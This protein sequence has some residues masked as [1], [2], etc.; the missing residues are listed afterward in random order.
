MKTDMQTFCQE[1]SQKLEP[2]ADELRQAL[3]ELPP[4]E[5][6]NQIDTTVLQLQEVQQRLSTLREK[7]SDQSTFLLIFG[8]LKS[9]KSTLMNALS[10]AYVSE[11]SSLPAYPALV[12][13]KNGD[14]H[15][16]QATD[17]LGERREF[18]DN[19]AL[20]EAIQTDHSLLADAIV[21]AENTSAS[22]DP[23]QHYPQAIRRM[24]IEI[25]AAHLADSGSV[26]VDTP[27]LYSR[28]KFGYDQMTRDFRDTAACAIFVVKTDNLFFEKVFEEFEELLSCFSR[29]FLV[30]NI[31]SSKQDLRP[32]GT[33]E[34]SLESSDPNKIIESFRSL[35]MS[36]TLSGAID[37]G[38]LKIY[39]V[40][41]Q[42]AATRTLRE[43]AGEAS[44]VAVNDSEANE[45][46]DDGFDEFVDDLT[47]YLN[48]SDY[49]HDFKYDSLRLAQDLTAETCDLVSD[50]ASA[51][52]SRESE[53]IREELERDR[54]RL[55]ALQ[56]LERQ[57]WDL[58]FNTLSASR[59]RMP[60]DLT[61]QSDGQLEQSCQQQITAWMESD[62][63]WNQLLARLNPE[64]EQE[65]RR[66]SGLVLDH[67]RAQLQGG[68][69]GAEFSDT[70]LSAFRDAG[71][72]VEQ[73]LAGCL[74][75]LGD[76]TQVVTPTLELATEDI[77]VKRTLGDYLLLR[78][79]KR[80][81]QGIF[82]EDGNRSVEAA[83]KQKRLG[84]ASLEKLHI[85]V[86]DTVG[87]EMPELQ[88]QYADALVEA[89]IVRCSEAVHQSITQISEGVQDSIAPRESMLRLC[90]Q[91]QDVFKRI[92]QS[93]ERFSAD[94]NELQRQ[95]DLKKPE[96]ADDHEDVLAE[97]YPQ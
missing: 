1:F 97:A 18:A 45:D 84:D 83:V 66:R 55:N 88:A 64:L 80:V 82:G 90:Q 87:R 47:G 6:L 54:T 11:V 44:L 89:H 3:N 43:A 24:D 7:V 56:T 74:Q 68:Y 36:A 25:P 23:Q 50:D 85:I 52:L 5:K 26:L 9:G 75:S 14:Q 72:Q 17:Y 13:V 86:R 33:L 4:R 95:F 28:M 16:F 65:G 92:E 27:G 53:R 39:P 51:A 12:Y 40:D 58:A 38:R 21:A 30:A 8:P 22:F 15:R 81:R 79:R 93:S 19:V 67:I 48:S 78:S 20:A 2:F 91:A 59:N 60:E 77:P 76:S 94:L 29:I 73:S 62:E 10:G 41:L 42:K 71:L 34:P 57:S 37:E 96:S 63:S 69:A 35:S 61:E 70:Q 31:D 32:D 46:R 49:L